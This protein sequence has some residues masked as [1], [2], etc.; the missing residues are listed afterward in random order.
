MKMTLAHKNKLSQAR[1]DFLSNGGVP[2]MFGKKHSNQTKEIMS[3]KKTGIRLSENHKQKI[4]VKFL[5]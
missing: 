4:K 5:K 2:P 1:K 3:R